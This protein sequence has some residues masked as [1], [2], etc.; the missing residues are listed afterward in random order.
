MRQAEMEV[1]K[2]RKVNLAESCFRFYDFRQIWLIV[3]VFTL[4]PRSPYDYT[5]ETTLP[6]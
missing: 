5:K 3:L 1:N 6:Q 2:L 4:L